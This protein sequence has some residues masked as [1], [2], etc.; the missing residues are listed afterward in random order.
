[1]G[2]IPRDRF[3]AL[4][5][6]PDTKATGLALATCT[7]PLREVAPQEIEIKL[8]A[9]A[10]AEGMDA[11]RRLPPMAKALR[12]SIA[13]LVDHLSPALDMIV[14]E[15]VAHRKNDPRPDNIIQLG[16]V[17]GLAM[18]AALIFEGET[19]PI[20]DPQLRMP[21]PVEWKGTMG[22][23][24]HHALLLRR[25][26]LKKTLKGVPGAEDMKPAHRI[27]VIDAIGLAVWGLEQLVFEERKMRVL[28]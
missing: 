15:G 9:S 25:M 23:A 27:H 28:R 7:L 16:V 21:L 3:Y 12:E 24:D 19:G 10:T 17:Q 22:K 26:H 6:D 11:R 1:M 18:G 14:V 20:S 4:G 2:H 5:V 13:D 8:V